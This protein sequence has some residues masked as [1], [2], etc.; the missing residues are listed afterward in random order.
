MRQVPARSRG[1]LSRL[2]CAVAAALVALASAGCRSGSPLIT[3]LPPLAEEA[4]KPPVQTTERPAQRNVT[5]VM[6]D[7]APDGRIQRPAVAGPLEGAKSGAA[8][9]AMA[10]IMV[11]ST[12]GTAGRFNSPEAGIFAVGIFAAGL[13]VAPVGA[14]LGAGIGAVMAPTR[15]AADQGTARLERA[16]SDMPVSKILVSE[17]R[18]AGDARGILFTTAARGDSATATADAVLEIGPPRVS[19]TSKSSGALSPEWSPDFRLRVVVDVT[20]VRA[21]GVDETR[22]WS[23]WWTHEGEVVAPFWDWSRNDARMFRSELER[24]LRGLAL[25]AV[26]ELVP[27]QTQTSQR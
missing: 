22:R 14:G 12:I 10:P 6:S 25:R 15:D 19:L 24:A 9:G 26:D 11:A 20:L 5:L 23:W 8:I 7:A 13:A 1:N 27:P 2:V 16:F 4:E 17:F 3:S 21:T 18:A